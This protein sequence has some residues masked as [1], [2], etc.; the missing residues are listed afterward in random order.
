MLWEGGGGEARSG[1]EAPLS[2]CNAPKNM[3]RVGPATPGGGG[4]GCSDVNNVLIDCGT[5]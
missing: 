5:L 2:P 1:P 4:G 3:V